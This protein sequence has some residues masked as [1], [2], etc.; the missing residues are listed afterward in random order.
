MKKVFFIFAGALILV[1]MSRGSPPVLSDNQE[2]GEKAAQEKRLGM[3]VR[4]PAGEYIVGSEHEPDNTPYRLIGFDGFFID[5][6]PV[7]NQQY[8]AFLAESHYIPE[9]RFDTDAAQE[10]PLFP[11][12]NITYEDALAYARFYRKRLPTEW[13]WEIAA[14]SLKKN[15][16]YSAGTVPSL[17]TGNFFRYKQKNGATPVFAY[18]PNELG[19]YDMS[20]NVFEWTSSLYPLEKVRGKYRQSFRLMVLRG[21]AWTNMPHDVRVTTRTPFPASRTLPWIGFRCVSDRQ[22]DK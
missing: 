5:I 21:G 3:Q 1:L 13:E 11:A 14:R 22:S 16:I 10:R 2:S 20:G 12:T 7:V 17:E 19:L 18:P 8:A 9:G 4:I 15:V 6:H